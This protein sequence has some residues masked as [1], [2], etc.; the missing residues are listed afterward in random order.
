M[1][2]RTLTSKLA[3]TLQCL[4]GISS[5]ASP[6]RSGQV[7]WA[8][9]L[10]AVVGYVAF[11]GVCLSQ[12]PT[13]TLLNA[14]LPLTRPQSSNLR[15]SAVLQGRQSASGKSYTHVVQTAPYSQ[16]YP[17]P[18]AAEGVHSNSQVSPSDVKI[19]WAVAEC[20]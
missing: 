15:G 3:H 14:Q 19:L 20:R 8:A 11:F 1:S 13:T 5:K 7:K 9:A 18:V 12:Q 6:G 17:A 2:S 16:S 4:T 10:G